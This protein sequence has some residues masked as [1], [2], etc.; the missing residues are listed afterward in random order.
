MHL[1]LCLGSIRS[2]KAHCRKL[3]FKFGVTS[4]PINMVRKY[5]DNSPEHKTSFFFSGNIKQIYNG[6]CIFVWKLKQLFYKK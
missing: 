5:S 4:N 6:N 1:G 3:Y 2:K